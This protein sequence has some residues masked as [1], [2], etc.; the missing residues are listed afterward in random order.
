M[1]A[2]VGDKRLQKQ[3]ITKHHSKHD[4]YT[5]EQQFDEE[6]GSFDYLGIT[7]SNMAAANQKYTLVLRHVQQ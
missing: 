2:Q 7:F 1:L 5:N 3:V 4:I 6:E